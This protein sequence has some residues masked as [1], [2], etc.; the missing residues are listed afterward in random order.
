MKNQY[1]LLS[2]YVI[3]GVASVWE[4]RKGFDDFLKLSELLNDSYRIV[5]VGLND[6]QMKTLPQNVI[7]IKQTNNAE[8]LAGIY[9]MA[10][11]F[12]NL[13]VEETMGLTTIESNACGTPAIVY[14]CTALP[15]FINTQNGRICNIIGANELINSI[16]SLTR[17]RYEKVRESVLQFDKIEKYKEYIQ[18]Y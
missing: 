16:L 18:L 4:K 15:E 5:L 17:V 7:G 10:D 6:K 11:V 12:L 8:E 9:S 2:K 1:G 13:S 14:N 3:L